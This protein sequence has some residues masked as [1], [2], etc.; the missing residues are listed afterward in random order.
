MTPIACLA[1]LDL[2][3]QRGVQ[4]SINPWEEET[5]NTLL[6]LIVYTSH[7]RTSCVSG[8]TFYTF[9]VSFNAACI[10]W[11][12]DGD[13]CHL[14]I[15][16]VLHPI[17]TARLG[18]GIKTTESL[19]F[20]LKVLHLFDPFATLTSSMCRLFFSDIHDTAD[21]APR[22][23][24]KMHCDNTQKDFRHRHVIHRPY[25]ENRRRLHTNENASYLL[26]SISAP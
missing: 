25:S 13:F 6:T 8:H 20:W 22:Q 24:I 3:L 12:L 4:H 11:V 21:G 14:A 5:L 26:F 2:S 10:L 16:I 1:V 15:V 9:C 19:V 17:D 18:V 7:L 23:S